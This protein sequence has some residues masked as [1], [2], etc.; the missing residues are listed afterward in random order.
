MTKNLIN[1]LEKH[2][3]YEMSNVHFAFPAIVKSYDAEKR[4]AQVLPSVKRKKADGSYV[5]LPII[6]DVPV[7]YFGTVKG[8]IHIPL[9][10]NDEVLIIVSERAIETWKDNGGSGNEDINIRRF[11]L[12]DAIA[13]PGLQAIT[14]PNIEDAT[15]DCL[16]IHHDNKIIMTIGDN[17]IEYDSEGGTKTTDISGNII[18]TTE[19]GVSITDKN[20]NKIITDDSGIT[21]TDKTGNKIVMS[22]SS[23]EITGNA[24]NT[25]KAGNSVGTIKDLLQDTLQILNSS[26]ATAGSP[27]NHTVVPGQFAQVIAKLAQILG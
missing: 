15:E 9:E 7:V 22:N 26:L 18:D 2:F 5:E 19:D 11:N 6:V 16:A 10:E 23:I 27:A 4:R 13:I 24:T 3:D 1:L 12:S 21:I 14:F 20:D 25:I 17:R 8:G